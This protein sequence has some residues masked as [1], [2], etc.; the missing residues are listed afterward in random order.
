MIEIAADKRVPLTFS[1]TAE[2]GKRTHRTATPRFLHRL[3]SR[4]LAVQA[5]CQLRGEIRHFALARMDHVRPDSGPAVAGYH[6]GRAWFEAEKKSLDIHE[7][8]AGY[9]KGESR[10]TRRLGAFSTR[11]S[12]ALASAV[13][14][15]LALMRALCEDGQGTNIPTPFASLRVEA[16]V[17]VEN[18]ILTPCPTRRGLLDEASAHTRLRWQMRVHGCLEA[19]ENLRAAFGL[20][21]IGFWVVGGADVRWMLLDASRATRVHSGR[22]AESG[23]R[24]GRKSAFAERVAAG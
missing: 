24:S 21:E 7:A 9:V 22:E 3:K 17:P 23:A 1:Y 11:E 19:A 16:G 2:S 10:L 6:L 12:L 18:A 14:P 13:Q 8:V 4:E 5:E 15:L 20:S